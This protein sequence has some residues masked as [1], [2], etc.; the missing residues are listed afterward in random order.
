MFY[1]FL[2]HLNKIDKDRYYFFVG[3]ID[4][5][6]IWTCLT[7]NDIPISELMLEPLE[8]APGMIT[9]IITVSFRV[10]ETDMRKYSRQKESP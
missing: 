8:E 4:W 9:I 3:E 6:V 5:E 10:I 7:A 1:L 2:Q